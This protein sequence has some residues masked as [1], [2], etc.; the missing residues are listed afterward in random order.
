MIRAVRAGEASSRGDYATA[1]Q[2][3]ER[4]SFDRYHVHKLHGQNI[5]PAFVGDFDPVVKVDLTLFENTRRG[6]QRTLQ[7]ACQSQASAGFRDTYFCIPPKQENGLWR[8]Q[9]VH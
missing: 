4:S 9:E 8:P 5:L 6:R 3:D 2:K 7:S 1:D